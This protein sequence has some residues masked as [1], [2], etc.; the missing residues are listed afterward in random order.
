[1]DD[2]E[3]GSIDYPAD[4]SCVDRTSQEAPCDN[5]LDDDHDG[6]IDLDDPG[7]LS[8][9]DPSEREPGGP[10]CDNGVDDDQDGALDFP[11]DVG[12]TDVADTLE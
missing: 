1:V 8:A 4:K 5:G 7:C 3:D 12:C 10:A 9:S 2:D 6:L 11:G